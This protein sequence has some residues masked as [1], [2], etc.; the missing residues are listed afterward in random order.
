MTALSKD[1]VRKIVTLTLTKPVLSV[2]HLITISIM[3]FPDTNPKYR[4]YEIK[5]HSYSG[6]TWCYD[7]RSFADDG[8][9]K[10]LLESLEKLPSKLG[11]L[12]L[13]L[14]SSYCLRVLGK[15]TG[16]GPLLEISGWAKKWE[17]DDWKKATGRKVPLHTKKMIQKFSELMK[18][19]VAV[20]LKKES[21][22]L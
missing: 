14:G 1:D 12:I 2:K 7:R 6:M 18:Q 21:K 13:E 10:V 11:V 22:K 4:N 3:D 15:G 20:I 16:E 19:G 9:A 8:Q 5:I 17:E